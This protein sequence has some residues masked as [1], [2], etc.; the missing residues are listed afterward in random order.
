MQPDLP[1]QAGSAAKLKPG[2]GQ[3]SLV[4]VELRGPENLEAWKEGGGSGW[5]RAGGR[6]RAA[7]VRE[8]G[9]REKLIDR[10]SWRQ[11]LGLPGQ[12]VSNWLRG[13]E[14]RWFCLAEE[15]EHLCA[16]V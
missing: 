15:R 13:A 5:G 9:C 3:V 8:S 4:R 10:V 14:S 11:Q 12:G 16:C 2:H 1:E 7:R 6:G